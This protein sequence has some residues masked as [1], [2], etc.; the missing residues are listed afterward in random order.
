MGTY[1]KVL[2]KNNTNNLDIDLKKKKKG[3]ARY[4]NYWYINTVWSIE[5]LSRSNERLS[6]SQSRP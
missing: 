4:V 6:P 5:T 2:P 1:C 3:S